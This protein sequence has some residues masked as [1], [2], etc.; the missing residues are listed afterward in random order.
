MTRSVGSSLR[1]RQGQGSGRTMSKLQAPYVHPQLGVSG[2][3][4]CCRL[5]SGVPSLRAGLDQRPG[6]RV[7]LLFKHRSSTLRVA[8]LGTLCWT[9]QR[10][11]KR[12]HTA[13]APARPPRC[14]VVRPGELSAGNCPLNAT[15]A[16]LS[17]HSQQL[18]SCL[19]IPYDNRRTLSVHARDE[20]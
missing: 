10:A 16:A 13:P 8:C 4:S 17:T 2:A 18:A 20:R 15:C 6:I 11:G 12:S 1:E 19:T 3:M 5:W 9:A 14:I 7:W